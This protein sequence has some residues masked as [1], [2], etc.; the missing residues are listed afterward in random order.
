MH[1]IE[2]EECFESSEPWILGTVEA[3]QD[4]WTVDLFIRHHKVKFKIDTGADVT[5][6]PESTFRE[7]TKGALSLENADKPLLGPGGSPLSVI[8]MSHESLSKGELTVQEEVYV[9]K[10]LHIALLG[11]PAILK[12]NLVARLDSADANILKRMYPKLCQGLGMV[13]Q[14]YTIKLKPNVTPFTLVTPRRVPLPLLGK[15]K[16]N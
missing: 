15:V 14:L 1:A 13:R 8:G 2:G 4:A 12:L 16:S 3:G 6:I 5:V 11:R 10:D 9:V 7:I